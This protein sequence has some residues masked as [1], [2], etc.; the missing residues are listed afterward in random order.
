MNDFTKEELEEL[1]A[2]RCYHLDDSFPADDK[3]FMKVQ[4]MIENYCQHEKLNFM[5]DVFGYY[6]KK[7]H[8]NFTSE[9]VD[10]ERHERI[11]NGEED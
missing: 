8:K 9:H 10:D 3:L 11:Y 1:A 7:C 4:S 5:G 2:S 6:C